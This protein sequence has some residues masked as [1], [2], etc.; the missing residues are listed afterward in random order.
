MM[1][2]VLIITVG[3]SSQPIVTAIKELRPDRA[4]FL[5]STGSKGSISQVT[6][7]GTPCEIRKG[8][9]VIDRL[10][11]IPTQT[12]LGDKFERDRDVFPIENPDDLSECYGQASKAIQSVKKDSPNAQILADYTGGTKT[13]S[14]GLAMAGIDQQVRLYLT[15]GTRTNTIRVERG[16]RTEVTTIGSI[17]AQRSLK[18]LLA[19]AFGQYNYSAVTNQLKGLLRTIELPSEE[20]GNLREICDCCSGLEAWDRFDHQTALDFL[21]NQMKRSEIQSLGIF[22]RR[23]I[24]SR[25]IIDESFHSADGSK[26]H[27]YE[28]I[29]DLLLNA[30]RRSTQERYD[31]AIGRLYRGLELLAQI[32]L[33][34]G[35]EIK[36]GDVEIQKLPESLQSEYEQ[37]RS[38]NTNKIQLGLRNSYDLLSQLSEDSLGELYKQ[39]SKYLLDALEARN[40]SLFAHGFQPI[41]AEKYNQV[42]GVI[43]DFIETG[44]NTLIPPKFQKKPPQFPTS[45]SF[46]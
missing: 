37:F 42:G 1:F 8:G 2:S 21:Q 26:G 41:D 38:K 4:I 7:E 13:M 5:C 16:E 10:P 18:Q 17:I 9:E 40:N 35:Y 14:V 36:T 29:Q 22:L 30:Q 3:G 39:R 12:G 11:N 32:R 45:L 31:D 43:I 28:V 19:S 20:K 46:S 44:I 15:T 23:V 25:E 6:G 34:I 27:G 33:L 24:A